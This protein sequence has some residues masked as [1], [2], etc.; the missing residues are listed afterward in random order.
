MKTKNSKV[1]RMLQALS[2]VVKD[3]NKELITAMGI[4]IAD[5]RDGYNYD[6]NSMAE[7]HR[8]TVLGKSY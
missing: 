6:F 7:S 8:I 2:I 5:E 1:E 3:E 4:V